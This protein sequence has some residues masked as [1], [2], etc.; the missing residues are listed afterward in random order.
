M[1]RVLLT[2]DEIDAGGI[3]EVAGRRGA[4]LVR[5]LGVRRGQSVRVGI[6]NGPPGTGRV[7]EIGEDVVRLSCRFDAAAGPRTGIHLV[8]ALPRPKVM[9]RLWAPLASLGVERITLVNAAR[10]ERNYFDTHWLEARAYEPLLREGAAQ[11]GDTRSPAVAVRRRLKPFVEDDMGL[12]AGDILRLVAEPGEAGRTPAGCDT[13]Q[14]VVLAV[15]PEG[16][17]TPFELELWRNNGFKTL[18]LG[19]RTL[20]SDVACIALLGYLQGLRASAREEP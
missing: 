3:V 6:V 18:C 7:L 11:A 15:G 17:W 10:V 14:Q 13:A 1:N 12:P 9:R 8:L 19:W 5:V 16:G 20:R 2:S 4:H